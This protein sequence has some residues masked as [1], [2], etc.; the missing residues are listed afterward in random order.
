M[1]YISGSINPF[2]MTVGKPSVAN[3]FVVRA[4]EEE[5]SKR[6]PINQLSASSG[7]MPMGSMAP[8]T[9]YPPSMGFMYATQPVPPQ[10]GYNPFL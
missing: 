2:A 1:L 3:P 9:V 6:V 10:H 8:S 5:Q 4:K 7:Q